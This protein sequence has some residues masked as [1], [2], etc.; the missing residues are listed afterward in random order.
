MPNARRPL[1]TRQTAWAAAL[2]RGLAARRWITPNGISATGIGFAAVGCALL[3][4]SACPSVGP[5][6][7]IAALVGAALM[8]QLRLLCNL[9]DGMVAVEG[10]R[11]SATGDLMNEVPDRVEDTLLLVGAGIAATQAPV[12]LGLVCAWLA[13]M[14]AYVRA[15]GA[16]LGAGQDYGGP[17]AKP[18]RMAALTAGCVAAAAE[19]AWRG[20]TQTLSLALWIIAAGALLTVALRLQR[21]TRF[22]EQRG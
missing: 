4:L 1:K 9:L 19:V 14:T 16:S 13:V 3:A 6:L 2:A 18:H 12:W 17:M 5:G 7:R 15:F 21:L 11:K 20:S 8:V 10:G 22:L